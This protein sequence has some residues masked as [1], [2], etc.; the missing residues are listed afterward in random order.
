VKGIKVTE[1]NVMQ[2]IYDYTHW[3]YEKETMEAFD[4][5]DWDLEFDD[6]EH[7]YKQYFTW[8]II[9][10]RN[11]ISNK[12]VLE[13]FAEY[14]DDKDLRKK[15]LKMSDVRYLKLQVTKNDGKFIYA[16][17]SNNNR[18]KLSTFD[19]SNIHYY[20]A[21]K[22]IE[23]YIFPWEDH[24]RIIGIV[25]IYGREVDELVN[26]LEK[27]MEEMYE[28]RI[29]VIIRENSTLKSILNQLPADYID[30]ICTTLHISKKDKKKNK[31]D[32]IVSILTTDK[33]NDIIDSL[34]N[35]AKD[36]LLSIAKKG[37]IISYNR[38]VKLYGGKDIISSK[39]PHTPAGILRIHGLLI[40]GRII[41]N[42]RFYRVAVIPKDVLRVIRL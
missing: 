27:F 24:Y 30:E 35:D 17:D 38:M 22:N 1:D 15:I 32:R 14:I 39:Q 12:T 26:Y 34:P 5:C 9:R 18:Y 20:K 3:K 2:L 11:P 23:C 33:V 25:K 7:I 41:K 13:E 8:F 42:N 40:V 37:G 31:I 29:S 4:K 36:A 6:E 16:K 10:W 19:K 21:G 28:N